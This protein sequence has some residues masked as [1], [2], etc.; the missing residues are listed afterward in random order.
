MKIRV[1]SDLH[2]EFEPFFPPEVEGVD[3]VVLAGDIHKTAR[4]LK[5]TEIFFP[6][7]P[8][9]YVA[10]NHEFYESSLPGICKSIR[11]RATGTN[12]HF[13]EKQEVMID[14]VR[15]LGCTLWT[16]FA[17]LGDASAA[18]REAEQCMTDFQPYVIR[19]KHERGTYLT[20]AASRQLHF[21]A[22]GWLE[23]ELR[24]GFAGKTVVVTHHAPSLAS[25]HPVY[26]YA[27]LLA[28]FASQLDELIELADLWVHGHTH[29][30]CDYRIGRARVVCN[31]K[32]YPGER[33]KTGQGTGFQP[34]LTVEV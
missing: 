24:A 31:P 13:L 26:R 29:A 23:R 25:I 30:A 20:A 15:F 28:A 6:D 18:I 5:W 8:V 4:A 10:G 14:G 3:V 19:C 9:V 7:T 1:F 11:E 34:R 16:D 32:G 2:L 33:L 27:L 17:L 22:R 12:V 21:A